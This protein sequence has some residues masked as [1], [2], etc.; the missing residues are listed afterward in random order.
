MCFTC[1]DNTAAQ[2]DITVSFVCCV[3]SLKALIDVSKR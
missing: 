2:D 1:D 3:M